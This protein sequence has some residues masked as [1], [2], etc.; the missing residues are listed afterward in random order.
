MMNTS[1]DKFIVTT[2]D[3][4]EKQI[5]RFSKI[6]MNKVIFAKRTLERNVL[7]HLVVILES[8]SRQNVRTVDARCCSTGGS[9][10]LQNEQICG[11]TD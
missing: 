9:I 7:L 8:V 4:H 11:Q 3:Y 2:D 6:H 10:F 1:Y 5:R